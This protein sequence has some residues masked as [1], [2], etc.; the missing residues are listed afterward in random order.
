MQSITS[1]STDYRKRNYKHTVF[2]L[3]DILLYTVNTT[4]YTTTELDK[5]LRG[6]LRPLWV[7]LFLLLPLDQQEHW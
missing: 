7:S 3:V 6:S 4:K 1:Y 2:I 5:H